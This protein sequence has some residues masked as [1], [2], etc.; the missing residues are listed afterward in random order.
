MQIPLWNLLFIYIEDPGSH[1]LTGLQLI[2]FIKSFNLSSVSSLFCV[3]SNYPF[4]PES[5]VSMVINGVSLSFFL[6]DEVGYY[7]ANKI[8]CVHSALISSISLPVDG[9]LPIAL[10]SLRLSHSHVFLFLLSHFFS[11]C[12]LSVCRPTP[13][14]EWRKKDGSLDKTS[15]QLSNSDRW[16]SFDSI[17]LNDQGEYEC[18]AFNIHGSITHSFTVTVEGRLHNTQLHQCYDM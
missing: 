10:P 18:R 13:K 8:M 14:V 3:R 11:S 2:L 4:S 15:G 1:S 5:S 6:N 17:T 12:L 16:L 9:S 7:A